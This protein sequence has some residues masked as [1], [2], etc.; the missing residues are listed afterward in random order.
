M[1]NT[2]D[3]APGALVILSETAKLSAGI[4]PSDGLCGVVIKRVDFY[5]LTGIDDAS[6]V[7]YSVLLGSGVTE[8]FY[9]EDL[10][11]LH[12]EKNDCR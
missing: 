12:E 7:C 8:N 2:N 4:N 3:I 6:P 1:E 11:V 5:S 9:R 10:E